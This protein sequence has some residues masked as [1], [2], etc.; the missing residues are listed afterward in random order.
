MNTC[1]A[2]YLK[3]S[4]MHFTTATYRQQTMSA[5]TGQP[6]GDLPTHTWPFSTPTVAGMAPQSR[7]TCS[8]AKAVLHTPQNTT[9]F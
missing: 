7:I 9:P 5:V 3:I 4:P 8:T 6:K 2:P 1:Q